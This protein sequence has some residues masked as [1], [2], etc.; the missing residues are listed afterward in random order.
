MT[1]QTPQHP[2]IAALMQ[3]TSGIDPDANLAH[4]SA[5][6]EQASSHGAAM[7][8]LPEMSLLLDRNRQRAAPHICAETDSPHLRRLQELARHH[9][10]WLHTGSIAFLSDDGRRRVNRSH[11]IDANGQIQA[12]YDKIHMFDV[13]LPTGEA[14]TESA[15]YNGGDQAVLVDTPLG[16][17]GLS[18][19]YDLRFAELYRR[20]CDMGAEVI[21]IPAAFTVPT[22]EAHWHILMRARAI[23]TACH[24]L[25]PAQCGQHADGRATYGHSL[26]IAPWGEVIADAGQHSTDQP[27]HM[28]YAA[29]DPAKRMAARSAVPLDHSRSVRAITL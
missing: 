5:A 23:E 14:W 13:T 29:I 2:P 24:I 20:L 26:A 12:R 19:C 7:L 4:I 10:I 18:I 3:M 21:T 17:M 1:D 8:L 22:G 16:K 6:M 28:I 25:A 9:R 11:V 15:L 27:F